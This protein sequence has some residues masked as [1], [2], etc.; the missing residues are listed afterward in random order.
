[1]SSLA[2]RERGNALALYVFRITYRGASVT[3]TVR[4]GFVVDEFITLSRK[5]DRTA[6]DESRLTELKQ[7]MADRVMSSPA[8][9]VYDVDTGTLPV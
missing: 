5:S 3:L 4:E 2:R 6:E 9:S 1:D 7:E 8:E